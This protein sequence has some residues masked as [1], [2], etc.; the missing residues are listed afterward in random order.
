[1]WLIN[2][3]SRREEINSDKKYFKKKPGIFFN[4]IGYSYPIEINYKEDVNI[5]FFCGLG[6]FIYG[7]PTLLNIQKN[8]KQSG[9]L[10]NAVISSSKDS[11]NNP[12][13]YDLA[14]EILIFDNVRY[15]LGLKSCYWKGYVFVGLSRLGLTGK[16]YP[17]IYNTNTGED[18]RTISVYNQFGF[19]TKLKSLPLPSISKKTPEAEKFLEKMIHREKIIFFHFETRSSDYNVKY[20]KNL[21]EQ[22][23]ANITCVN[24]NKSFTIDSPNGINLLKYNFSITETA[25]I[26]ES[27]KHKSSL[28]CVN[29]VFWPLSAT[30]NIKTS[31][32]HIL[33]SKDLHHFTYDNMEI[34]TMANYEQIRSKKN[35]FI[36]DDN[37]REYSGG[38][39]VYNQNVVEV[40]LR[41]VLETL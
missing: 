40:I 15:C 29:S 8:C 1:M 21:A 2:K 20:A 38:V 34:I 31:A 37:F 32:I 9:V 13:V 36:V 22:I 27:L 39:I 33:N 10:F 30:V 5:C 24:C 14:K 16:F 41:D 35:I 7:L 26:L 3:K 12:Q 25:Y 11:F 17:F 23:A 19:N 28:F 4:E 6:D 18:H